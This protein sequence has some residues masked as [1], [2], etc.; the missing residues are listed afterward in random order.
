MTSSM[1]ESRLAVVPDM[2]SKLSDFRSLRI[3]DDV[4]GSSINF[5]KP[6]EKLMLINVVK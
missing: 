4:I 6:T 3:N 2:A 1:K 5:P